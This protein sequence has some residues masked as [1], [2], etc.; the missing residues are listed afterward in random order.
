MPDIVARAKAL[1]MQPAQEWPVIAAEPAD[2]RS[3]I[4]GYAAPLS[5]I[6]AVIGLI[7]AWLL[8]GMMLMRLGF[9]TLLVHT[10]ARYIL[11][12]GALWVVGKIIQALAPKFGGV[13]DEVSA[14][15]LSVY[16]PTAS[17]VASIFI[18]IPIIGFVLALLGL[19]YSIYLFYV[20]APVVAKIPDDKKLPFTIVVFL[21]AIVL[22]MLIGWVIARLLPWI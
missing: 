1:I 9:G 17:W 13:D 8:G 11:G 3:L 4:L 22:F 6:P 12:L 20:G 7:A 10:I 18:L 5:L 21:C 2:T 19:I 16:S 15:K 14:M